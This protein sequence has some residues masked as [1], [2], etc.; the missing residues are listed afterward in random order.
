VPC[1]IGQN[2]RTYNYRYCTG[3][4]IWIIA[5]DR[6]GVRS[7]QWGDAIYAPCPDPPTYSNLHGWHDGELVH[8]AFDVIAPPGDN[9]R[10]EFSASEFGGS[11]EHEREIVP[12]DGPVHVSFPGA[13][14]TYFVMI[15]VRSDSFYSSGQPPSSQTVRAE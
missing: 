4:E 14:G 5:T 15:I 1:T 11:A 12:C 2:S 13:S 10:C 7:D 3:G 8:I 9:P 6:F